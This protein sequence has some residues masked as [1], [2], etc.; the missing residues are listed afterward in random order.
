VPADDVIDLAKRSEVIVYAIAIVAKD[1]P[2]SRGWADAELMLRSLTRETGGRLF[3]ATEPPQLPA[4][5]MQVADELANQYSMAYVSTNGKKDGSWRRIALQV[6]KGD[7]TPRT[8][9]GYY[10]TKEKR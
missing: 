7:A 8:R 9:S 3:V 10:A 5:Y 1:V 4:I 6:L 2:A